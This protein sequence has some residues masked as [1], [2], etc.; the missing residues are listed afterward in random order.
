MLLLREMFLHGE[1]MD[2]TMSML[3][4][5][6]Y[7]ACERRMNEAPEVA[8]FAAEAPDAAAQRLLEASYDNDTGL[9]QRRLVTL[10]E[11]RG[12]VLSRMA[13]EAL[14]LDLDER[15]LLGLLV[16]HHGE[17]L[18]EDPDRLPAAESLMRR[19][20]CCV[21]PEG[22]NWRI[23]LPQAL[24]APL[25][26]ALHVFE[27]SLLWMKLHQYTTTVECQLYA[28]GMIYEKQPMELFLT[29]VI[30]QDDVQG[31]EI[32][33][34]YLKASFD[35]VLDRS[36]SLILLHPGLV[37]PERMIREQSG[38]GAASEAAEQLRQQVAVSL[39]EP[40]IQLT[41]NSLVLAE[42]ALPNDRLCVALTE[43]VRP[44]Y[45]PD[46]CAEDLRLLI[47]Q[48]YPYEEIYEAMKAMLVM[49]PT[50]EMEEALRELYLC[51]P[52]WIGLKAGRVQ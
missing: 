42:E 46:E 25:S 36:G 39:C 9:S 1:P 26:Q 18:L 23:T 35:Y 8:L 7:D 40:S 16:S 13:L 33:R 20:W 47:K 11:L 32:G 6:Q 31:R 51:T 43:A 48:D 12:A 10:D 24:L 45:H 44:D 22:A 28:A 17:L 29:D 14:F 21:R 52:R 3:R 15:Y 2:M 30:N 49:L 5:K 41:E 34:R 4:L 27:K 50:Q 19:L 38:N 37:D